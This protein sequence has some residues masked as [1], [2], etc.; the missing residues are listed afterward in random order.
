MTQIQVIVFV[1]WMCVIGLNSRQ[2]LFIWV[3]VS[4]LLVCLVFCRGFRWLCV[5]WCGCCLFG[6]C[7]FVLW[8]LLSVCLLFVCCVCFQRSSYF[9]FCGMFSFVASCLVFFVFVFLFLCCPGPLNNLELI[10]RNKKIQHTETNVVAKK[11]TN[12][13]C[14]N[15]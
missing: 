2:S 7:L 4:K 8:S 5:L 10:R 3:F 11:E 13:S 12:V 1:L 6:L 15:E 14:G 9:C